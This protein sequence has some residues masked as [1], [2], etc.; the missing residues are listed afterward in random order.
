MADSFGA[1][2]MVGL[3]SVREAGHVTRF[4]MGLECFS[5]VRATGSC[6]V[7]DVQ[8]SVD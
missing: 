5:P 6:R 8:K 3:L 2:L 1:N 7:L 4:V